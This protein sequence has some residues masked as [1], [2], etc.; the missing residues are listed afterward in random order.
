[1]SEARARPFPALALALVH[2]VLLGCQGTS[3]VPEPAVPEQEERAA[4]P[5][6]AP[7]REQ[8]PVGATSAAPLTLPEIFADQ[9]WVAR[10]PRGAF[11]GVDGRSV[12]HQRKRAGSDVE[13]RVLL[14]PL[15]MTARVL[16][17]DE[18][19]PLH[20]A[21]W[22]REPWR[23]DGSARRA[24]CTHE[25][26]LFLW[27]GANVVQLTRGADVEQFLWADGGA[28][29][30]YRSD[31][32][33][34]RL[35]LGG[36]AAFEVARVA[37]GAEPEADG[38]DAPEGFRARSQARLIE[39][40][41]EGE[42]RERE[43]RDATRARRAADP[44]RPAPAL[45]VGAGKRPGAQSLAPDGAALAVVVEDERSDEPARDQMPVWLT[46]DGDVAVRRVRPHVGEPSRAAQALVLFDL[47]THVRTEVSLAG[48]TDVGRD[49]LA[50]LRE[51]PLPE[52]PRALRVRLGEWSHDGRHL[53]LQC[54]S[55]DDK[56]RWTLVLDARTGTVAEVHHLHDPAWIGGF[57]EFGWV[58]GRSTLWFLSEE[59]GWSQLHVCDVGGEPRALTRGAFEVDDVVASADGRTFLFRANVHDHG[60]H[61]V[62]SVP[63]SGG[64]PVQRTHFGGRVESFE[65]A[66][67]GSWILCSVSRVLEPVELY[68]QTLDGGAP[69]RLTHT[70]EPGFA[71]RP[72]AEPRFV[73]V[74]GRS[75]SGVPARLYLPRAAPG[76]AAPLRPAVLFVHG[77]GYLQNAH[78]GFSGYSREFMFHSFLVEQGFVVLDM[79]YRAS[80]G[81]GR[82][83][84]TAI[85][86]HMGGPELE[87]LVDGA[88]WLAAEHGVDPARI[89]LYGGS[90]GGFLTL[91][92]LFQASDVF[93]CGAALRPVTDW[94]HY[95][96]GYTANILHTPELD[97]DAFL[98]SSPIEFAE[99]LADPLLVCHG[100][101]D[102]NVLAK[103]TIRLAQRLIELGKEDFEIMLYPAE[104]HAFRWPSSWLDEYRRIWALFE[105][106]LAE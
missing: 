3:T 94:S 2:V 80:A 18:Y 83:W 106:H 22:R 85:H 90:Y 86:R 64:A 53:A 44:T 21:G 37:A 73:R 99:G 6:T 30:H 55:T 8:A 36:G 51:Q 4:P 63:S 78:R 104:A 68:A 24:L 19:V 97:P 61:E 41:R 58:P 14:D 43:Q 71:A 96:D 1:M 66:P 17:D 38:T 45:H 82:D 50:E 103:D 5:A 23:S 101:V 84:R 42:R 20:A 77:A 88:R 60:V 39:V 54:F 89:G 32:A 26:D 102:D 100:L 33:W 25:R 70:I 48:L 65:L 47:A 76:E 56:D 105:E 10:S 49:P 9:D 87:D 16:A 98:R 7:G 28:A 29:V 31:G 40:V 59:S 67:D 11:V 74:P 62:W 57:N 35:A 79:D 69:R 95:N 52:G 81:Y 13:D 92:A 93:A 91:M 12:L 27:D 15:S 72:W 46:Q 34:W 75:G